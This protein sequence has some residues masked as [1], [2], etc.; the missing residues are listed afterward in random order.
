LQKKLDKKII[1]EKSVR[2]E[3]TEGRKEGSKGI[4]EEMNCKW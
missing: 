1:K 2:Q 4:T 3:Q